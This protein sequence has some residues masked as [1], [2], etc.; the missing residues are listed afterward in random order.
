VTDA[1]P[2]MIAAVQGALGKWGLASWACIELSGR[3][4]TAALAVDPLRQG[5]TVPVDRALAEVKAERV[6]QTAKHGDQ[7]HL[8]NGTGPKRPVFALSSAAALAEWA[9]ERTKAASQNEGGDGTIT[10]EHILTEEW[11][12]AIA[13]DDEQRLRAELV[14]VAA[15][16][17]Q[18]IEA[19]DRRLPDPGQDQP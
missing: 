17:V 9:K 5:D 8:P 16:A 13:E 3:V 2:E 18:W 6:R 15:V 7:A 11:A 19:I 4:L 14:Q 10:F 12:E 1:T